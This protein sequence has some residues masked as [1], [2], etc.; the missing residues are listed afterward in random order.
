MSKL[1]KVALA[2]GAALFASGVGA[3][4]LPVD[5]VVVFGDSL[6][7]GGFF[8]AA[9]PLIPRNA[10]SFTTNPDP[11]APEVLAAQ[12]GLPL[13]PVYGQNGTN[14]AIGGA[15]VTA[16]NGITIPIA[17]Q[18]SN[19]LTANTS[20]RRT[21]LVYIQGGGNDFFA[22]QGGGSAD[23]TI[24]T[25]AATQLAQTVRRIEGAGSPRIV[26]L[27]I[28]SG[29]SP[30]IQLFNRTYAQAL[31]AQ[32]SNVLFV[33][34]DRL[35]NEIVANAGSFGITNTTGTACIGSS[36]TC[37]PATYVTPNAN[38]TYLLADSVHPAGITQEIQGKA[39]ASLVIAPEQIANLAYAAQ[40][41][42]RSQRDQL[43]GPMQ[44]GVAGGGVGL[45]GNLG[46]HYASR[47][48]AAQVSGFTER[49]WIG[50]AGIDVPFGELSGVGIAGAYSKLDG[51]FNSFGGYDAKLYSVTGY[52]RVGVGG[53]RLVVDGTF[54]KVDYDNIS[55]VV[56]LGPVTRSSNGSTEGRFYA[57]RALASAALLRS[58][59]FGIGPEA[60]L[61][62]E[63]VKL[64][65]YAESQTRS[66]DASFGGQR[67]KSLTG[68]FGLVAQTDATGPVRVV[69]RANYV[70]EF[71]DDPRTIS[72]TPSG[73]PVA[74][75]SEVSRA[76]R[77][78]FGGGLSVDGN[79][80]GGLS[81]R[82]G[83]ATELG[84][85]DF[86]RISAHAGLSLA[87]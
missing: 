58:G 45:Y 44:N 7:D 54:G 74:F 73:A 32:N 23:N 36:L 72:I 87:F 4:S 24:L 17:N 76:D 75:T 81:V 35:F 41:G 14:Y 43:A 12:L 63:R 69:A 65:G 78:Y 19:F 68:R 30:A 85:R 70:R 84:R 86:D 50:S 62:Y 48:G 29:G 82:G 39:I 3:Q 57:A 27:S 5:R 16:P 55:R 71:D 61:T 77:S 51:S 79:L 26:T 40:G 22:F 59:G 34:V 9:S 25:T 31:A 52:G 18:V 11:V 20:F 56:G 38:R 83:F 66:T 49:G 2:T 80:G 37:T 15:R 67:L 47:G 10:G 1:L 60:S 46:Y 8:L 64:D 53:F 6:S 42:F 13:L 28:Q 33:D 21:D